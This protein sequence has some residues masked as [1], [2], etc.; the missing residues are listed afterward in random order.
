MKTPRDVVLPPLAARRHPRGGPRRGAPRPRPARRPARR[1]GRRPRRAP[2]PARARQ[3][4]AGR[5]RPHR[6]RRRQPGHGRHLRLLHEERPAVRHQRPRQRPGVERA[7]PR[8]TPPGRHPAQR[9]LRERGHELRR[10]PYAERRQALR[11]DRRGPRRRHPSRRRAHQRRR[12]RADRRR[13]HEA[14]GAADPEPDARQHLTHTVACV[15]DRDCTTAYSAGD[16]GADG[17]FS[18]FDLRRLAK[19]REV[20]SNTRTGRRAVLRLPHG[21][22]QVELRRGR[23]RHAHRAS[24]APRCGAPRSR[25]TRSW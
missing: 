3:R 4:R 19:P 2:G 6:A 9:R 12:R 25:A 24:P 23:L 21:R 18:I 14:V 17:G 11:P 22:S 15:D 16:S 7:Q 8:G 5:E 1:T 20:D 13:R 10:A